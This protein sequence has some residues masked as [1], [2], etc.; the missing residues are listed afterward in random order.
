MQGQ[1]GE[2]RTGPSVRRQGV[3]GVVVN[4]RDAPWGGSAVAASASVACRHVGPAWPEPLGFQ[5]K[6]GILMFV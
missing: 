5:A 1:A 2:G 3:V 6:S 4:L